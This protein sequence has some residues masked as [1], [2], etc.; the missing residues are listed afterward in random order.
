M[1]KDRTLSITLRLRDINHLFEEPNITPF[2]DYYAPYSFKTGMD[3]IV[4]E[5]YAHPYSPLIQLTVQLPA[6][7][8]TPDLEERTREAIRKYSAA[9]VGDARQEMAKDWYMGT[10]ALWT[11]LIA[12]IVLVPLIY[13]LEAS[14]N[15][16][17]TI[18]ATGPEVIIWLLLWWPLELLTFQL[19]EDRLEQ[20]AYAA[21]QSIALTIVAEPVSSEQ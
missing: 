3:Y 5:L 8:I 10:R 14:R 18:L 13:Y 20:R 21:L 1:A 7:S 17:Y 11:G 9:W 15:Y 4:G 19:W 6:A 16:W 2:S 12:V